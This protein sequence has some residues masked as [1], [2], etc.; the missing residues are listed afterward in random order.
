MSRDGRPHPQ[1]EKPA[2]LLAGGRILAAHGVRGWV[3]VRSY[4]D[5]EENLFRYQPWWVQFAD[6]WRPIRPRQ[7]R[8]VV[9]GFL[10]SLEG[11]EDRDAAQALGGREIHVSPA[12]F[13]PPA[14]GEV[15]WH[16][17]MGM[18]V[19]SRWSGREWL[20]GRVA[21][22][23]ETGANDVVVVAPTPDSID[24]RERLVPFVAAHVLDVDLE[25]GR[26][27]V[28]WDPEF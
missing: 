21:G 11:V 17:L 6:G 13:P 26:L 23:L 28:E 8:A 2:D 10:V 4:T 15:Y 16:Q 24:G 22:R 19:V 9:P 5:P 27:L 25:G 3:K 12:T 7:Y 14:P 18:A 1:A 20:L